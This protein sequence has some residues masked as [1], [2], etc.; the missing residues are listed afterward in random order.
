MKKLLTILFIAVSTLSYADQLA[1][2][3]KAEADRAVE[4]ISKMKSVTLFCGCCD[5]IKPVKVTPTKVYALATGYE[6]YWEVYVEYVDA[7][8]IT[9]TE[10]MDLAY[11]WKK[12]VFGYKTIGA[13]L[14]LEHDYCTKPKNWNKPVKA[15]AEN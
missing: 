11:V 6:E 4:L 9:Q 8:G 14:G 5:L 13:L 3:T 10:P 2:I 15:E 7:N 12:G 1:Y